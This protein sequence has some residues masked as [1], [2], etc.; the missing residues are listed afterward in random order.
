MNFYLHL[1]IFELQMYLSA[2]RSHFFDIFV[3]VSVKKT[4][5]DFIVQKQI[6]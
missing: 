1:K 3:F 5:D 6:T 2:T 4:A